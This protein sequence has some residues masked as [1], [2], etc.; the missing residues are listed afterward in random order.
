[1]N[2]IKNNQGLMDC[3]SVRLL[4][5]LQNDTIGWDQH[6]QT[7]GL[8]APLHLA[9]FPYP[10]YPLHP[11]EFCFPRSLDDECLMRHIES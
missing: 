3:W 9:L 6:L 2:W 1:M 4:G 8:K 11:C 10:F 7:K 5:S